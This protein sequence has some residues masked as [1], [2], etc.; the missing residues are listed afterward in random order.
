MSRAYRAARKPPPPLAPPMTVAEFLGW[1]GDGKGGMYELVDGQLRARTRTLPIHSRI[2]SNLQGV[3]GQHLAT[4]CPGATVVTDP[5]IHVRVR[6][7]FNV[8]I[9]DLGVTCTTLHGDQIVLPD[10]VLLIEI[11]TPSNETDTWSNVWA[12]TTIPKVREILI[13]DYNKIGAELLRRG[14]D[15]H[16]PLEPETVA[17]DDTLKLDCIQLAIPLVEVYRDTYHISPRP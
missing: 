4:N 12:Y 11:L 5:A 14:A 1:P 16:W 3:I 17:A 10:P 6:H 15:G 2:K 8:R 7:N 9:P 13:V